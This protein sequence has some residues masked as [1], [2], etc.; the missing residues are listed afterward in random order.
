MDQ[1]IIMKL[2]EANIKSEQ[3]SEQLNVISQQIKELDNF[4]EVLEKLDKSDEKEIL[5]S[6]GKG[7]FV[8]S[9]IKEK[10]FFVDVGAG[11]F[12]RKSLKDTGE[13]LENQIKRLHEMKFHLSNEMDVMNSEIEKIIN[14]NKE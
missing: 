12:V 5:S 7:V 14:I 2:Q 10:T 11:V 1:E 8:K 9:E 6:I 4:R 13:V 3:Y